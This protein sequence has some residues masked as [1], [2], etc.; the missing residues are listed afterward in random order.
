MLTVNICDN[1]LGDL[2][3][4]TCPPLC[5]SQCT[6]T[7]HICQHDYPPTCTGWGKLYNTAGFLLVVCR[8][9]KVQEEG[10]MKQT[11]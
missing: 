2:A 1:M 10:A 7:T 11:V 6:W 4:H 5:H 3:T 9:S 8:S